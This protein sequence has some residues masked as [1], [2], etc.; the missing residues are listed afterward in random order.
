VVD[1]V[2][3]GPNRMKKMLVVDFEDVVDADDEDI[4]VELDENIDWI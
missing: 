4:S 3:M 1:V 2:V